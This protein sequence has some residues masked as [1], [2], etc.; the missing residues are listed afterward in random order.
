MTPAAQPVTEDSA[1][2]GKSSLEKA[3]FRLLTRPNLGTVLAIV[4]VCLAAPSLFIGFYLDDFLGRYIYTDLEGA[5]RLYRVLEGGYALAK[6]D[7]SETHWQIEEGW[8]P[9]WTYDRLILRTMRPIGIAMHFDFRL[10]PNNAFLMHAHNLA[11]LAVL[12]LVAT[13]LYR[14]VLGD[15]VGGMAALLFAFDHTHG[16]IVGFI[17][18]R[19]ALLAGV[20]GF[21][22]LDFAFRYRARGVR[23]AALVLGPAAY[24]L[25]LLSSESALAVFGYLFAYT[26]FVEQGSVLKRA[27]SFA[28][29]LI[30][31]AAYRA[32]YNFFGYG[33]RGSG[34]YIDPAR[35]PVHFLSALA[36][37]GPILMLGQF[38]H[39]PAEFYVLLPQSWARAHYVLAALF[40]LGLCV[41]FGR[42]VRRDPIARFWA[43]G[44]AI[45]LVPAAST[46]P[47]N[48][49]LLWPSLG[50][51]G[52]IAQLWHLYA[53]ELKGAVHSR[54]AKFSGGFGAV[55]FFNHLILSPI[56]APVA[57]CSIVFTSPLKRGAAKVG[58]EIADRDAVFMTAPDYFAV[59]LVQL[60]R[61]IEKQPL[62][63]R[64]RALSFGPEPVSVTRM[65]DHTL[66]LDYEGGILTTPF[67]E[68][69]RDRRLRMAVGDTVTLEGLTI[70]VTSVTPDGR[71]DRASFEFD[72]PLGDPQFVFY[73]WA[74]D[75][76]R[77]FVPPPVGG[78]T[79]LPSAVVN[80]GL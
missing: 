24:V 9:W 32:A 40:V 57:A 18:N 35:D 29:F 23:G 41:A 56:Y 39:P 50:A 33:G 73:Y 70:R 16:F 34:L 47:H 5:D 15:L 61:R 59:K 3:L 63:R 25:A 78:V 11:W 51:M 58:D 21:A 44:M 22:C 12:V 27:L 1:A 42:L 19:H 77:R 48:R 37:R 49:Q 60:G 79:H 62:A 72:T 54:L 43:L 75:G 10:W 7:P 65:N 14:G 26:L 46:Y 80:W 55:V 36:E 45:S 52:L 76:F 8:A 67:M 38:F 31:T 71:A 2:D 68:L 30:I 53:V 13:R 6:G 4:A 74:E 20:F 28:P 66:S 64:W 17:C 69:Y